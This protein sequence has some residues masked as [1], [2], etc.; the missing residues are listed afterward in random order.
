MLFLSFF[1]FNQKTAYDIRIS[2]WSSDV[3]SSDLLSHCWYTNVPTP[4]GVESYIQAAL[5]AQALG[6]VLP[7][8]VRA[9]D[10]EIVGTTR[11]H[12]LDPAVPNVNI[13][14]KSVV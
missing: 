9:A 7:F 2:D 11:F 10:G 1:F 12:A 6:R 8:V 14:R 5:D 13:D 4:D 3:C